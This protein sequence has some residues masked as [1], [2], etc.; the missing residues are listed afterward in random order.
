[1][2]ERERGWKSRG[3]GGSSWS[4]LK[5][6]GGLERPLPA[7]TMSDHISVAASPLPLPVHLWTTT[8]TQHGYTTRETVAHEPRKRLYGSSHF[9]ET[10]QEFSP[11]KHEDVSMFAGSILYQTDP[12]PRISPLLL[13]VAILRLILLPSLIS[14]LLFP[15][16]SCVTQFNSLSLSLITRAKLS[17]G[18]AH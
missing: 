11:V 18:E 17:C 14:L 8:H 6:H 1:M 16:V 15:P 5:S 9:M 7:S 4:A 2:K 10:A 12:S 13:L 3:G